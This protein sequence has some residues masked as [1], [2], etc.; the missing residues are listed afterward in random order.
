MF[1]KKFLLI[2]G[3]SLATFWGFQWYFGNKVQQSGTTA[4]PVAVTAPQQGISAGPVKVISAQ[5]FN[6]P[7][8]MNVAFA[9]EKSLAGV[10]LTSV[11]TPYIKATLSNQGGAITELS[12]REHKGK[13]GA[14]MH[15]ILGRGFPPS[16]KATAG[17]APLTP[18]LE[19]LQESEEKQ[20]ACFMLALDEKTPFVY[21]LL[22][23]EEKGE[24]EKKVTEVAYQ[25]E[26]DQWL[27]KK[28]YSIHHDSYQL[29]VTVAVQPKTIDALPMH[30]RLMFPAPMVKEIVDDAVG[31]IAL[32]TTK[33][34]IDK[35]ELDKAHALKWPWDVNNVI[36]G[37]EDKYFVHTLI[38]DA[39]QFVQRSYIKQ[40]II[41]ATK[42]GQMIQ[43]E[44]FSVLESGEIKE[45]KS[46]TMSFYMGPKVSDQLSYVDDRL[47]DLMSFGWLS[48][49]CKLLLKLLEYLHSF[50]GNYGLA[51]LGLAF[52]L[53][54]PLIPLSIYSRRKMEIYQKFQPTIQKIRTKYRHD[55]KM[56]H[57]ELM[58]FHQEHNLSTATP[59]LGCLPMLVQ[60]PVLFALFRILGNYLDLYQAPFYGWIVDLSSKDP[61]Y[62]L[63][64]LMGA[65]MIW[66]QL[67]TPT[68]DEKQ[69][70]IM[71][72][73]SLVFTV[74]FAK[75]AAGLVLYWL[76]NNVVTIAEDYLRKLVYR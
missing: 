43:K 32:D 64:V 26:T 4:G 69:R 70:V 46:W 2:A 60:M 42:P 65:S 9:E 72:F 55:V 27:L 28:I 1:D 53:R 19:I 59:I 18:P 22:Y 52:V 44:V 5:D 75:T 14:P 47:D 68:T 71:L 20:K 58:K 25:A 67:M 3:L 17:Q 45:K 37:A 35:Y 57:E 15:T 54:I 31:I 76:V 34:T 21:S 61:Y 13:D 24:N 73:M 29:D 48:W 50:F 56:Q 10:E 51:I 11:E 23:K 36:F 7:L 66:Q 49:L 41:P 38:S 74:V 30:L 33:N 40:V 8:N 39:S 6:R 63:P 12:F 16:H 62:V